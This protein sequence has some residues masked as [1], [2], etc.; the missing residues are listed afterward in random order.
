MQFSFNLVKKI[1]DECDEI[2]FR[3]EISCYTV[4]LAKHR[5]GRITVTASELG[6]CEEK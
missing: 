5:I 4:H 3:T 2:I 1:F 6:I